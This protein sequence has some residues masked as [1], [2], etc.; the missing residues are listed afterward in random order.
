MSCNYA[1]GIDIGGT[2]LRLGLVDAQGRLSAFEKHSVTALDGVSGL[3]DAVAEY[4]RRQGVAVCAVC[5][6]FPA[7]VDKARETV[8]DAPN[9]KGFNG[10]PVRRLLEQALDIPCYIERDVN[11]LLLHDLQALGIAGGDIVACYVGTGIGN[12]IMVDGR[13]LVGHN[14]VAGELGH[15][16]FGTSERACGCGNIGCAEPLAGGRYLAEYAK[17]V[18]ADIGS[19][20][21]SCA[22]A[23]ELKSFVEALGRVIAAEVNIIDPETV[24]LGG[25]VIDMEGFPKQALE[26]TILAHTRKPLPY[27]NLKICYSAAADG[28]GG[29]IGAGL[30]AWR[31]RG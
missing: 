24:L 12:A 15:I 16:P 7:T 23:P 14:G 30:Y 31:K 9:L 25:G 3:A 29:V 13:L 27:Q 1:V 26:Q 11:L 4:I 19:L 10:V 2:N 5:A 17:A 28:M 20:F 21:V 8:L 6:G 22:D 18:G